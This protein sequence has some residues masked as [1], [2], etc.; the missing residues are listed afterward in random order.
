MHVK[1]F[2]SFYAFLLIHFPVLYH[3]FV[4]EVI[5]CVILL[6]YGARLSWGGTHLRLRWFAYSLP[7][8]CDDT[9]S[10]F[11]RLSVNFFWHQV[12]CKAHDEICPLSVHLLSVCL[13]LETLHYNIDPL[14]FI[15]GT[16]VFRL[17]LFL[18]FSFFS[19]CYLI[20]ISRSEKKSPWAWYCNRIICLS[21]RNFVPPTYKVQCFKLGW[22]YSNRT[23]NVNSS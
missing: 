13:S 17:S 11:G 2:Q 10:Y 7:F 9:S 12:A 23:W 6:H 14:S 21:V 20:V 16:Y 18:D 3:A 5:Y 15:P 1:E 19:H 22:W 4:F 8:L